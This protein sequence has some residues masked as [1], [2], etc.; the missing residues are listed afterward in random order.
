[1]MKIEIT[2][3]GKWHQS[4]TL[5]LGLLA[6]IGLLLL[7]PLQMIKSVIKERQVNAEEVRQKISQQWATKQCLSGPVLNVPVRNFILKSGF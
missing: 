5:K 3:Q 4:L 2:N 6:V 1:M 7:I